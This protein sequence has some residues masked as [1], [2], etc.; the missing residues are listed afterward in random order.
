M[1]AKKG[2]EFSDSDID[3][4]ISVYKVNEVLWRPDHPEYK[5]QSLKMELLERI[6]ENDFGGRYTGTEFL[7]CA[8]L[9]GRI[10]FN[11]ICFILTSFVSVQVIK[12][13]IHN[14][15]TQYFREKKLPP[16]G[17]NGKK[18]KIWKYFEDLSFLS[19]G[20]EFAESSTNLDGVDILADDVD[21]M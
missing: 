21:A 17:S 9:S 2:E 16:T 19:D 7:T 4:L 5:K 12:G 3:T 14:L 6:G 20:Q 8:L 13:K 15:R 1:A 18:R 11:F 10:H